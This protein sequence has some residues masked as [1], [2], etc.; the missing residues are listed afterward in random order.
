MANNIFMAILFL[1]FV[2][3]VLADGWWRGRSA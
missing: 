1:A 2:V 3:L